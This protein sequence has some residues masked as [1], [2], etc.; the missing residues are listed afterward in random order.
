MEI[1]R[2]LLRGASI[3][4]AERVREAMAARRVPSFPCA[5]FVTNIITISTVTTEN[6]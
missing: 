4:I 3:R 6:P 1:P 2:N 5:Q